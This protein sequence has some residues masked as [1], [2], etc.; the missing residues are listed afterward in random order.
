MYECG[1]NI[2]KSEFV[3]R[4]LLNTFITNT[5]MPHFS[6][7]FPDFITDISQQIGNILILLSKKE[8]EQVSV[9]CTR[10]SSFFGNQ[11]HQ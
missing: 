3:F 1:L 6:T 4:N 9:S 7:Q 8:G 11:G 2:Y 5:I 10:M